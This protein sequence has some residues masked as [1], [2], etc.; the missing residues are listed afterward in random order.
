MYTDWYLR[1]YQVL[2]ASGLVNVNFQTPGGLTALHVAAELGMLVMVICHNISP[3][4]L[5]FHSR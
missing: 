5:D 3:I 4:N 2:L 1:Y